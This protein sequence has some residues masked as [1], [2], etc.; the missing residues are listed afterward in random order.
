MFVLLG[1]LSIALLIFSQISLMS[2]ILNKGAIQPLYFLESIIF[3]HPYMNTHSGYTHTH[4]NYSL[5]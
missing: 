1:N 3:V 2:H 4:N 5:F